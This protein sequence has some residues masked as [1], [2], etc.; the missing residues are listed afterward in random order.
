MSN[1]LKPDT[2]P[3]G[4]V[5]SDECRSALNTEDHINWHMLELVRL[6]ELEEVMLEGEVHYKLPE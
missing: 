1:G 3:W 5:P 2:C 4:N 6:G